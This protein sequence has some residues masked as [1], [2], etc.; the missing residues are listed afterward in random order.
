MIMSRQV[1]IRVSPA[2]TSVVEAVGFE[3]CGCA[4]ATQAVEIAIGGQAGKKSRDPK[5]E[6]Y[7]PAGTNQQ[8][9]KLTF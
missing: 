8:N 2:G 7:A 4:D 9:N 6:F 3:G 5:P 1:V